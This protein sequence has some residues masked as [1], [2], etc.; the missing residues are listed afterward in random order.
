MGGIFISYRRE[1]SAG[2]SGRLFDRLREQFGQERV[3]MDVAGIEPGVD[4]VEAIDTAVG[5]CDALIVVIGRT[6]LSCT[7]AVGKRRLDDPK[8]FIR[9]ETG[10]ALRRNIRVIPVLVQGA[11]MPTEKDL[12]EDLL[13]LARRQAIAISDAHWNS[14]TEVLIETLEKVLPSE[15]MP[16]VIKAAPQP[17]AAAPAPPKSRLVWLIS[18]IT[19][20]VVA[21][22]GLLSSI[23]SVKNTFSGLFASRAEKKIE[24]VT[25][26]LE[27]PA[28]K[29]MVA[30]PNLI[31]TSR[32]AAIAQLRTQ[33]LQAGSV[34]SRPADRPAGTVLE[35]TPSVGRLLPVGSEV[36]LVL[37]EKPAGPAEGSVAP[38]VIVPKLVDLSQERAHLTLKNVGLAPGRISEVVTSDRKPGTVLEQ[39]PPAGQR[40]AKGK[41]V[42]LVIAV[43]PPAPALVTVPRLTG[44]TVDMAREAL[45]KVGLVPG[46]IREKVYDRA[47][48]G[49]VIAHK[50]RAG[51]EVEKGTT[52]ELL[53][54]AAPEKNALVTVPQ[55]VGLTL[56]EAR[57]SL[58]KAG[59]KPGVLHKERD[60]RA[61]PGTIIDQKPGPGQ[62]EMPGTGVELWIAAASDKAASTATSA[63]ERI[64]VLVQGE[65]TS[66][67][68]WGG[69]DRATY[70]RNMAALYSGILKD[71][72]Q[73][74]INMKIDTVAERQVRVVEKMLREEKRLCESTGADIIFAATAQEGFASSD[75]ESAYW[76]ELHLVAI[77]CR[78]GK[79][80]D[81]RVNLSPHKDDKFPF[82]K[83]MGEAMQRFAGEHRGLLK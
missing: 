66:K 6:W 8:D 75:V 64:T 83:A 71:L 30:V 35:Q 29:T 44:F 63:A 33:H 65:P 80:S 18:T 9:L 34:T 26:P 42:A 24:V 67:R 49:M 38:Q 61:R 77:D 32:D 62:Q 28:R 21:L 39:S 2:H 25:P 55:L 19:A 41:A 57:T 5:S 70:S 36:H 31:G 47:R 4:F 20:I 73:H 22:G 69:K 11:A 40:L 52:V 60:E 37:A 79:Q 53:I 7:D 13:K 74:L 43:A 14:D 12:P 16:Q 45:I 54:A 46:A 1:D 27:A 76:P 78:N 23:E 56:P 68:F 48:P 72:V 82:E 50:P 17:P 3:F 15:A 81:K 59:L 51:E 58:S 10:A